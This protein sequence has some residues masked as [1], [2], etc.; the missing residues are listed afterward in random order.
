MKRLADIIFCEPIFNH[1][2]H[3]RNSEVPTP[4]FERWNISGSTP[5]RRLKTVQAWVTYFEAFS[6][7]EALRV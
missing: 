2:L 6:K 3:N 7:K 5:E 1:V 4:L